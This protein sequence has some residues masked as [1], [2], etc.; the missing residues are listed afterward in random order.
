MSHAVQKVSWE[1]QVP[2]VAL[3][4]KAVL[5][6]DEHPAFAMHWRSMQEFWQV[7]YTPLLFMNTECSVL[8][9]VIRCLHRLLHL[10]TSAD[11]VMMCPCAV[12][13]GQELQG[14]LECNLPAIA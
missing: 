2:H 3:R 12:S 14:E 5:I 11:A 13:S 9:H 6:A 8:L 7:P 1:E 4:Q 10:Q